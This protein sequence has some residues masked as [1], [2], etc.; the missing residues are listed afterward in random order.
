MTRFEYVSPDGWRKAVVYRRDCGATTN[1]SAQVVILPR[2]WKVWSWSQPSPIFVS[3]GEMVVTPVWTDTTHLL[4]RYGLPRPSSG[5]T[6]SWMD[7]S[8]WFDYG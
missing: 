1:W 5:S 4:V 3:H 7:D 2:W 6:V 8:A